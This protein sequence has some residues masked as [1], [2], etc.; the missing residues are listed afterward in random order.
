MYALKISA[1]FAIACSFSSAATSCL[2]SDAADQ[3]R[4]AATAYESQDWPQAAASLRQFVDEYP[5]HSRVGVARY[6]LGE[7]CL[8]LQ[9]YQEARRH[10]RDSLATSPPHAFAQ[11]AEFR[12]GQA[13]FLEGDHSFAS[14]AL[15]DFV[16]AYPRD[17][18]RAY[19][20]PYLGQ[21]ATARGDHER[22][23]H[24]FRAA[25]AD[26]PHGPLSAAC[27]LAL[28]DAVADD[29][30][31]RPAADHYRAVIEQD[32]GMA[33][34]AAVKLAKLLCRAKQFSAVADL[35]REHAESD[36]LS[37]QDLI[38]YELAW[39]LSDAGQRDAARDLFQ[40]ILDKHTESVYF[41]DAM[42]WLA[43]NAAAEGDTTAALELL[44]RLR[45][46]PC[47]AEL[48][49]HVLFM[50]GELYA[51]QEQWSQ[52]A[53]P[54]EAL[55]AGDP[56]SALADP[57]RYWL[58]E[59]RLHAGNDSAAARAFEDLMHRLQG[60]RSDW[61][62]NVFL[63]VGQL[64]L[65]EGDWKG[66]LEIAEQLP[67]RF[68]HFPQLYES[69]YLLGRCLMAQAKFDAARSAYR[70]VLRSVRGADTETAAK[71]QWMLG[72][73]YFHQRRYLKALAEYRKLLTETR[74]PQWQAAALLQAAKCAER[75]GDSLAAR[76]Q[77]ERLLREFPDSDAAR[78]A[79]RFARTLNPN[80]SDQSEVLK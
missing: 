37:Q 40:E 62:A 12:I 30:N 71:A 7:T 67:K 56:D 5:T 77:L 4:E 58:A 46:Q 39:A 25:L 65:R 1:A 48:T 55:L 15:A 45:T 11:Q 66:G 44:N 6:F 53:E 19:A 38:R 47:R 28:A 26:H 22:A 75:S 23:S 80:Q 79:A 17:P 51:Q 9:R 57:A 76:E 42:F 27:H 52:V 78:S 18:L 36:V 33:S 13:A 49:A 29:Q 72:E 2:A 31:T 20:L 21:M 35:L 10:F 73:S 32:P 60:E 24:W 61:A 63:R 34:E 41:P 54:L 59:A 74:Y 16:T 64:R 14:R 8:Q 50:Q 3:F 70:R 68:P 43:R 69:D